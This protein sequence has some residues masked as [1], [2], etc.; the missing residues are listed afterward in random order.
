[1]NLSNRRSPLTESMGSSESRLSAELEI[2]RGEIEDQIDL[3]V[4][5][6]EIAELK[7]EKMNNS[8]QT[9]ENQILKVRTESLICQEELKNLNRRLKKN[10]IF[11]CI[12]I[13]IFVIALVLTWV[14]ILTHK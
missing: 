1:M 10:A 2:L 6:L 4:S 3:L 14:E 11:V 12:V 8:L 9:F 7:N 13:G 5:E